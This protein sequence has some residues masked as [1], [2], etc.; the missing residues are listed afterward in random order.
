MDEKSTKINFFFWWRKTS[1][2]ILIIFF[3][4]KKFSFTLQYSA[5]F[6][7]FPTQIKN[8]NEFPVDNIK[9]L[10]N[11]PW[12][13]QTQRT[14]TKN[15]VEISSFSQI[16]G[17][18]QWN[19]EISFFCWINFFPLFFSVFRIFTPNQEVFRV[20][21]YYNFFFVSRNLF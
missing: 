17:W 4:F 3:N 8:I 18:Q 14:H 5:I 2:K 11:F 20:I 6:C 16:C 7:E 21:I 9:T 10:K 13:Q 19:E 1:L 12:K 15:T